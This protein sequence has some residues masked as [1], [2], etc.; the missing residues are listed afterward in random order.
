M[1]FSFHVELPSLASPLY[2]YKNVKKDGTWGLIM[3]VV[4]LAFP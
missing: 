3:S 2:A 4:E 1:L